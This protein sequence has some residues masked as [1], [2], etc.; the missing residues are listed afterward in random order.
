M[1]GNNLTETKEGKKNK[2]TW[3]IF[4]TQAIGELV[5]IHFFYLKE[6]YY[7]LRQVHHFILYY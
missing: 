1:Q 4:Y 5:I 3:N 6:T 7:P 2:S